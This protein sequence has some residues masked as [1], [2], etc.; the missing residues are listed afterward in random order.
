MGTLDRTANKNAPAPKRTHQDAMRDLESAF[1]RL[2]FKAAIAA[3]LVPPGSSEW[4]ARVNVNALMVPATAK[5]APAF[6]QLVS[7][8]R[9]ADR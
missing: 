1:V 3:F 7:R 8:A 4:A 6:V 5:T 9:T 2:A